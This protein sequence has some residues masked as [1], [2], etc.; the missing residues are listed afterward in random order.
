TAIA[1]VIGHIA[2]ED[3][4]HFHNAPEVDIGL[5]HRGAALGP[6]GF[7]K[8]EMAGTP[9]LEIKQAGVGPGGG[10]EDVALDAELFHDV[11][12]LG[13]VAGCIRGGWFD[14]AFV[15]RLLA[16]FPMFVKGPFGMVEKEACEGEEPEEEEQ[17]Q[18][19]V[20]MEL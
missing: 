14:R 7:D 10:P 15:V 6:V 9:D 12:G 19:G 17:K 4:E 18:T 2:S 13:E 16:V 3:V 5:A 11:L 8:K 20:E 1:R